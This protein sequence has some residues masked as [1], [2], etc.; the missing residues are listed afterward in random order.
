MFY[1]ALV[2]IKTSKPLMIGYAC[3]TYLEAVRQK[4]KET[5][6]KGIIKRVIKL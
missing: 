3:K 5:K 2:N 6:I 1:N 4:I